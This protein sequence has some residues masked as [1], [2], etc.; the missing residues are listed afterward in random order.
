LRNA[1]FP[2]APQRRY[3]L[4]SPLDHRPSRRGPSEDSGVVRPAAPPHGGDHGPLWRLRGD[5]GTQPRSCA[6]AH[7]VAPDP[8]GVSTP[9]GFRQERRSRTGFPDGGPP[10]AFAP[11]QRSIAAL[12]HRPAGRTGRSDDA[13][14]PGLSCPTTHDGTADPLPVAGGRSHSPTPR[15]ASE[16]SSPPSRRPPPP[17]PTR[18]ARRSVHGLHPPRPSPHTDGCPSRSPCPRDVDASGS[19]PP[20]GSGGTRP[21]SGLRSRCRARSAHALADARADALLGFSPPGRSPSPSGPSLWSR[22]L[23]LRA[24]RCD[25]HGPHAP[26]GLTERRGRL[27]PLGTAGPPGVCRLATVAASRESR[28]RGA[29]SWIHLTARARSKRREPIL[30]PSPPAR[31]GFRPARRRRLGT[32]TREISAISSTGLSPSVAALSRAFDYRLTW[33]RDLGLAGPGSHGRDPRPA[34]LS[35]LARRYPGEPAMLASSILTPDPVPC[36][37]GTGERHRVLGGES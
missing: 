3:R 25:V 34:S 2:F 8:H 7:W 30:A 33:Y 13:S 14:S 32:L 29:G 11:L 20:M 1:R 26:W 23:P 5:P 19:P 21:A 12:P 4:G 31:P 37:P 24:T 17:L 22:G 18:R 16:V 9:T 10:F 35:G 28:V 27:V 36:W 6:G 15:A